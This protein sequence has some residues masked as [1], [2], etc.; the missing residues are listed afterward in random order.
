[1]DIHVWCSYS[2]SQFWFYGKA[3]AKDAFKLFG[4]Y[5]SGI[6][7]NTLFKVPLDGPNDNL[8]FLDILED[9]RKDSEL[10]QHCW[11]VVYILGII[12]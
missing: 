12:P 2:W 8:S 4:E 1:M 10:S 7:D 9:D 11:H 6:S 3:A 5:F